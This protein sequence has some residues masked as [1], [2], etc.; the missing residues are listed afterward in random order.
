MEEKLSKFIQ[1]IHD[2][3]ATEKI[4][5]EKE[6][7]ALACDV[8]K[9]ESLFRFMGY[10]LSDVRVKPRHEHV[11]PGRA[12]FSPDFIICHKEK[13]AI[14][15]EAKSPRE[16]LKNHI[17]QIVSYCE[18][19]NTPLGVLFNGKSIHVFANTKFPGLKYLSAVKCPKIEYRGFSSTKVIKR[20]I[21]FYEQPIAIA[22]DN[23]KKIAEILFKL[24]KPQLEQ[25]SII[26]SAGSLALNR[27]KEIARSAAAGLRDKA[28][29]SHLDKTKANPSQAVL[30]AISQ[31]NSHL[32]L[33]KP[34]TDEL[35][36]NWRPE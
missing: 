18:K 25:H 6:L 1:K 2:K 29:R 22:E 26:A 20:A 24:S 17:Y 10:G 27:R 30:Q 35:K 7:E 28:I 32:S 33:L 13:N 31:N 5:L 11:G 15:F 3:I 23:P 14:I 4:L 19:T 16:N 8:N 9:R 21:S 12:T 34:T 36:R